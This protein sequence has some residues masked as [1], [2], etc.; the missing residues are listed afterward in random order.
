MVP[1]FPA[2]IVMLSESLSPCDLT[3]AILLSSLNSTSA[4]N[5]F[6]ASIH[7][8]WEDDGKQIAMNGTAFE[9]STGQL[10]LDL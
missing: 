6:I 8:F 1:L 3:M 2:S 7:D 9:F 4:P 10:E 5:F